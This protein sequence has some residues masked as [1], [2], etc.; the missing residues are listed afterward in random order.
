MVIELK[1]IRIRSTHAPPAGEPRSLYNNL[2]G[3]L[4]R[5]LPSM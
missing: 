3:S 1:V 5:S 2:M 4:S